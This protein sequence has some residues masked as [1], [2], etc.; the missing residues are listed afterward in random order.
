MHQFEATT[1]GWIKTCVKWFCD[2]FDWDWQTETWF[3]VKV[4]TYSTP[5]TIEFK[6]Y[7][8]FPSWP[9]SFIEVC[10]SKRQ[11][12]ETSRK[13]DKH[14]GGSNTFETSYI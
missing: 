7:P 8:V 1:L 14:V 3:I 6:S 13:K 2:N 10:Q 9:E 12:G 4:I 11:T 5:R